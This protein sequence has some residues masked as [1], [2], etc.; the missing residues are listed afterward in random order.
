MAVLFI[1]FV[2]V[3]ILELMVIIQVGQSVGA[4]N[5]VIL[6]VV[7][8]LVGAWLVKH[9][10]I[11]LLKK[12]QDRLRKGEL[13]SDE[14]F[15]GVTVLFAGALMLTPGFLTDLVGLLLL[16][17]PIRALVLMIVRRKFRSRIGTSF[18]TSNLPE[19]DMDKPSDDGG[20]ASGDNDN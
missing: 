3:P 16:V 1:L 10:G 18:T 19:W 5:T 15:S 11:G 6:L 12:S 8:S 13:P 9:Q 2:V 20:D 14:I 7:D 4:W 17:P